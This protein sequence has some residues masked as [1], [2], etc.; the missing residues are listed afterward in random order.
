M[1]GIAD[2]AVGVALVA[3]IMGWGPLAAPAD[4]GEGDSR[5]LFHSD[6]EQTGGTPDWP[7]GW[8]RIAA[9]SW[10]VE[11]GNRFI[12]LQSGEPGQLVLLYREIPLPPGVEALELS[13]RQRI[14]GLKRG[15]EPW[16]DARILME[17]LDESRTRIP[18][19]PPTPSRNSDTG[20]WEARTIRF[21]VPEGARRLKFMPALFRVRSG[22]FDLDDV[23]L[24]SIPRLPSGG[25]TAVEQRNRAAVPRFQEDGNLIANGSLELDSQGDGVPDHWGGPAPHVRYITEEGNTFVRIS[26]KPGEVAMVYRTVE[27]PPETGAL[28]LS[29]RWRVQ[30]LRPGAK[31]WYDARLLLKLLDADG[32]PTSPQPAAPYTRRSTGEWQKRT[33]RFLVGE[34]TVVME[35]M[36]T[37]FRVETGTM[38]IDDISLKPIDPTPLRAQARE[39]A[40]K[41]AALRV[42]AEEPRRERWPPELKVVGNRLR[43]PAGNEVW[44]QGV[45]IASLEWNPRGENVLKSARVALEDWKANAIRLPVKEEYW[46]GPE[47]E[48]YRRLVDDAITIIANRGAYAILDLHRFR[49]PRQEHLEFWRDAA[50]RYRNHPAVLFDVFNEPHGISWEVWRHGGYVPIKEQPADEDAFLSPEERVKNGLGFMSVGMQALVDGIRAVGA[51]NIV[52][53][54]G[55]DWAY[56]LSG[57]LNGYALDERENGNGIMYATHVYPWKRN[58]QKSFLEAAAVYPILVGEVGGDTKKMSWLPAEVQE[59][60]ETWA[61]DILGL[62]QK[63]RLHYTAWCFHPRATPRLLLDWE[64]TPT[65]FWG[66][67]VRDAMAGREF[68]IHHGLR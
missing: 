10:E 21:N 36:P 53:A 62:I 61:P 57:V 50:T 11:D 58:W 16:Y 56:D 30:D 68:G 48:A 39:K 25:D 47:A 45:N 6:F 2:R 59:D 60:V 29:W 52:A 4:E 24:R 3:A 41:D 43:D 26:A 7:A 51:R 46:F 66:Q 22:I 42:E 20:D 64:Y 5:R 18:P 9:A 12:R 63:H 1:F 27:V 67:L 35:F 32:K 19:N 34:G 55:L 44:L 37:L 15:D 40:A 8:P 28:E 54:G 17:F 49:A 65:P 33:H 38:D 31:P 23:T 13:W 14:K